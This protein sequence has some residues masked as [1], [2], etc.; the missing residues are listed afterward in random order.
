MEGKDEVKEHRVR[1]LLCWKRQIC[2]LFNPKLFWFFFYP[3]QLNISP[4]DVEVEMQ[5]FLRL[6]SWGIRSRYRQIRPHFSPYSE[7]FQSSYYLADCWGV[8]WLFSKVTHHL[9]FP[10][11]GFGLIESKVKFGF[12][13]FPAMTT[14]WHCLPRCCKDRSLVRVRILIR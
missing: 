12:H 5:S 11:C 8:V 2:A 4:S 7:P 6:K 3:L 13:R 9:Y 10:G 1:C 14:S